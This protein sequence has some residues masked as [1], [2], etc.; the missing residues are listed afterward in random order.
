MQAW[1]DRFESFRNELRRKVEGGQTDL[2]S[3][4][5]GGRRS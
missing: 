2:A 5:Q 3:E 4:L 1:V